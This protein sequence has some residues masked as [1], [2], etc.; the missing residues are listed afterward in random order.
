[1]SN[2]SKQVS[3]NTPE[4]VKVVLARPGVLATLQSLLFPSLLFQPMNTGGSYE[5][6]R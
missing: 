3:V 6:P 5:A 4:I 2:D 1:M